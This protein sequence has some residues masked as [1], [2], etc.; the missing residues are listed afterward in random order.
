MEMYPIKDKVEIMI[1]ENKETACMFAAI[2]FVNIARKAIAF[3]GSFSVALSGGSTPAKMYEILTTHELHN[4]VN[5][6]KVNFFWSDE[7]S[8]P[9]THSDSNYA[10]AMQ[11]FSKP[12]FN[13][14]R[15]FRMAADDANLEKAAKEY[16]SLIQTHCHD[17]RFDLVLL[18]LGQDGHTASLFPHTKALEVEDHL[19]CANYI[20]RLNTWRMTLT[21]SCIN[22]A[23]KILV[24]VC[25]KDKGEALHHV[26]AGESNISLYP[27]QKLGAGIGSVLYIT[28]KDAGEAAALFT[29]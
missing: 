11:Y 27:A 22:Q 26:L 19:A 24:L 12:P 16:E 29:T 2:R 18:G 7:R 1:L 17:Q 10:M 14:A 9:A 15:V 21:F 20:A 13:Q 4:R 8:V 5:W 28:D 25:G 3:H 23:D 6:S